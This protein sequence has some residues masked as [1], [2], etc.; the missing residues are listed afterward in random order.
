MQMHISDNKM[1]QYKICETN[2]CHLPYFKRSL[3]DLA[4]KLYDTNCNIKIPEL[5]FLDQTFLNFTNAFE[6]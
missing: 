5:L 3:F 4:K 2:Q 1:T 6:T